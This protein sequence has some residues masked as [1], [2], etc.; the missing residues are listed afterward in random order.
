MV[1]FWSFQQMAHLIQSLCPISSVSNRQGQL[2][3]ILS[4]REARA[5][6]FPCWSHTVPSGTLQAITVLLAI[7]LSSAFPALWF[8]LLF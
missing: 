4:P 1:S 7:V 8:M 5:L 6:L 2:L 3:L